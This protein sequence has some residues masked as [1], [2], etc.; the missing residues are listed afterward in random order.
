M[1]RSDLDPT[2]MVMRQRVGSELSIDAEGNKELV[3]KDI[4]RTIDIVRDAP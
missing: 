3:S 4:G 2:G 1:I